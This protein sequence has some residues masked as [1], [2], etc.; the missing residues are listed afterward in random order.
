M[1]FS[2]KRVNDHQALIELRTD[3]PSKDGREVFWKEKAK[4][5]QSW[6]ALDDP[7]NLMGDYDIVGTLSGGLLFESVLSKVENFSRNAEKWSV[8]K[9]SITLEV[10]EQIDWEEE[11]VCIVKEDE[12][13]DSRIITYKE[14]D[15]GYLPKN[16]PVDNLDGQRT[17]YREM[18][19]ELK[20]LLE[21]RGEL[22]IDGD[23]Y[24]LET[25]K[26]EDL[27]SD[28][29]NELIQHMKS[30]VRKDIE[31]PIREKDIRLVVSEAHG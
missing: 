4:E 20:E 21:E 31:F 13:L 22:E 28:N 10:L 19:R 27:K 11:G 12:K 23:I 8:I 17:D 5:T 7:S 26:R 16:L 18:Y 3:R 15:P 30:F 1:G 9:G 6:T 29:F 14:L 25:I 24:R 2:T